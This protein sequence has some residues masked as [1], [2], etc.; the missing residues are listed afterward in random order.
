M[1]RSNKISA[2][3][4]AAD[5]EAVLTKITEL[6][7]SMPFMVNLTVE[8]RKKLKGIGNKNL[9]YVQKCLEGALA[10]PDE[11]KKSFDI[12][13]FKR[14]VN[15]FNNLVGV[16]IACLTLMD[17]VDDSMKAAGIDSMGASAEV[18]ASL[19]S[20]AKSNANVKAIVAE[21]AERYKAQG[22]K[23]VAPTTAKG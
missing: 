21:I 20:S 16:Q 23:K 4:S 3:F 14:D 5:K 2:D 10:F 17:L 13:E 19:K 1:A 12:Q 8:D 22:K 15:L 6:K 9:I 18:Y 11:L 7:A